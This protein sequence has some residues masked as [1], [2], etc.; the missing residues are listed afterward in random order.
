[1]KKLLSILSSLTLISATATTAVACGEDTPAPPPAPPPNP[2]ESPQQIAKLISNTNLFAPSNMNPDTRNSDT[3][4]T[5][6]RTLQKANP[7]ITDDYL[8]F[9]TFSDETLDTSGQETPTEVILTITEAGFE[10]TTVNLQVTVLATADQIKKK[11][12]TSDPARTDIDLNSNVQAYTGDTS[13]IN[14]INAKLKSEN[15]TLKPSD[16]KTITYQVEDLENDGS[17]DKTPVLATITDDQ[18]K[19]ATVPLQVW[20]HPTAKQIAAKITKTTFSLDATLDSSTPATSTT[21]NKALQVFNPT[22]TAYDLEAIQYSGTLAANTAAAIKVHIEDDLQQKDE[23]VT[24]TLTKVSKNQA[25][26]DAIKAKI[27]N[28]RLTIDPPDN[29][30]TGNAATITLL[31]KSLQA[32]NAKLT[33]DVDRPDPNDDISHVTFGVMNLSLQKTNAV[34]VNITVGS[35][36]DQGT[37]SITVY[38]Q[39]IGKAQAI[40]DK[41][42]TRQYYLSAGTNTSTTN[43]GTIATLKAAIKAKN[44]L[45]DAELAMITFDAATLKGDGSE[46]LVAVNAVVSNPSLAGDKVNVPLKVAIHPTAA[47]IASK[48]KIIQVDV[49]GTSDPSVLNTTTKQAII[50]QVALQNNLNAWDASKI[51][52]TTAATLLKNQYITVQLDLSDDVK[53]TP[54]SDTLNISV[55]L[56]NLADTIKDKITVTNLRIASNS[57]VSTSDSTTIASIKSSLQTANPDLTNNDLSDISVQAGLTLNDTGNAVATAV[58][59]TITGADQT[60]ATV[61]TDIIINPTA[62]QFATQLDTM[63][64]DVSSALPA[65]TA[66]VSTQNA[67]K[68]AIAQQANVSA[69]KEAMITIIDTE[70]LTL[71]TSV[72]VSITVEDDQG[73]QAQGSV[74]VTRVSPAQ[75][76]ADK[77]TT[78]YISIKPIANQSTTNSDTIAK[79]KES[80]QASN[81]TLTAGDLANISF[82]KTLLNNSGYNVINR[83]HCLVEDNGSLANFEINVTV[84]SS[85]TQIANK[86][87]HTRPLLRAN[88][89][90]NTDNPQDAVTATNLQNNIEYDNRN[91]GMV[92]YETRYMTFV[93]NSG[94]NL[95]LGQ[96]NSVTATITDANGNTATVQIAVNYKNV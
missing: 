4:T 29:L 92:P 52:I 71:N 47:Q 77:V 96:L 95:V 85:A 81:A 43:S 45:T 78:N 2:K 6:K 11:I 34:T 9:M 54:G 84:L 68:A 76:I 16:L 67:I 65:D 8:N 46:N 1:M 24:L 57:N 93:T 12:D 17:E 19:T 26:A 79:I 44:N 25:Q 18:G 64:F 51:D 72:P 15:P 22:L 61:N 86:F 89:F 13:T 50:D 5:L 82:A 63:K 40:A 62:A 83:L 21:I 20:I 53:P 60:A 3:V 55:R 39:L 35:L 56:T 32:N 80:L 7:G 30:S 87:T 28:T 31:K 38:W 48:I 94:N 14:A 49:P 91:N 36:L 75:V 90:Q 27:T 88:K 69:Y 66:E 37:A 58:V 59:L 73:A 74:T 41:I 33:G 10:S 42:T 70:T 23:S